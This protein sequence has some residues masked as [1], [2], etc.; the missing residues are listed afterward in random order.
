MKRIQIIKDLQIAENLAQIRAMLVVATGA[1]Q[2]N[3]DQIAYIQTLS[4]L[5]P[6]A[7]FEKLLQ[8]LDTQITALKEQVQ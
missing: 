7:M 6:Q 8:G 3:Q 1:M 2:G 5:T 4:G